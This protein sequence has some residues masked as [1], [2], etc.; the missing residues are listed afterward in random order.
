M[1]FYTPGNDIELPNHPRVH[2]LAGRLIIFFCIKFF[3]AT[4]ILGRSTEV[5]KIVTIRKGALICITARR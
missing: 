3:I 4:D 1:T 2:V 5:G